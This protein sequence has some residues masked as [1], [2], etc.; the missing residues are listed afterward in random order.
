MFA[1]R[2]GAGPDEREVAA[3]ALAVEG[4][5]AAAAPDLLLDA[6]VTRF[7]D[8]YAASVAPLS[9][10]LR[11][12][13]GPEERDEDRRWQWLACRLAQDL[14]DDEL[15]HALATR[16]VRI[17]RDAG[18]LNLLPNMLNYL[19]A[20]HV[21]SGSFAT[22]A[23]LIDEVDAITQATGLPQLKYAAGML[24]AA[25]GDQPQVLVERLLRNATERGEGSALGGFWSFTASLHNGHGRYGE[26]LAA[27]RTACEHQD[28][29]MYGS[30][31]VE[32]IEAGVRGGRP[33]EAAAALERLT[34]RTRASGTEWALGIE[35]RCRALLD[36]DESLYRESIDRLA[37][38]H[39]A[40]QLARSRLVYGE[41]L[42]RANRR[43]DAREVLREAYEDLVRMG[44]EGFA[45]RARRELAATGQTVRRH[46]I[47]TR[48]ELTAQELQI[49]RLADEGH[50][51]PQIGAELFLSP[52]TVE[53]HLGNVFAKLGI[54]SRRQLGDALP[55]AAGARLPA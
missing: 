19:A 52:R 11:A 30:A 21:H 10:A 55:A 1:G 38:S 20:F 6:L 50:T 2:L 26:A 42:R 25:R 3:A 29:V 5:P 14:W 4:G 24:A 43:A 37:R 40:L 18:A 15:W 7:T 27:A 34:E 53:W 35:A 36:D 33:Y 22:A 51:N 32:L 49:A 54:S 9:R 16:G 46:P 8:G 47:E 13:A 31:L 44:A 48:D 45:E 12:F 23:G 28:V 17:A 41:W 39:A